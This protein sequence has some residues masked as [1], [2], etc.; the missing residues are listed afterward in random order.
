MQKI[1]LLFTFSF[2]LFHA[3]AQQKVLA[4]KI[5]AKVGDRIILHSD[6]TNEIADMKR[7]GTPLPPSATCG[8]LQNNILGKVLVLQAE[9]DSLKLDDEN[10]EAE[11]DN[12]IR[13]FI[14][15]YGSKEALEE[16]AGKTVYQIKED[17]KQPFRERKLADMMRNKIVEDVKITPTEVKTYFDKIPKDSL[18]FYESALEIGQVVIYP[19]ANKDVDAYIIQELLEYKRQI[20]QEH[21]S[22]ELLAKLYSE[23][24]GSKD[25]GGQY[26]INRNDKFWDPTFLTTAFRLKE[27]QISQPVKSK[28]GYHIIQLVKRNGDDAIVRHILR[29]PPVNDEELKIAINTLDSVRSQIIAGVINFGTAVNKY[30][31]DEESKFNGGFMANQNGSTLVNIDQLDKDMVLILKNMKVNDISQPQVYT[32]QR[33]KK[34][35]RIIYLK[36]RTEPHRENLKD[37]YNRIAQRALD[38]KKNAAM[39]KW[40]NQ[41]TKDYYISI[42][43]EYK[44]CENLSQWK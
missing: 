44:Q 37:D 18:A 8:L 11:L 42:D 24:P 40:F 23:D 1:F 21:K 35:V 10:L 15:A 13:G 28:F 2:L 26:T 32:D 5:I 30:S 31:N 12:Q 20:E 34:A 38:E 41:K 17:F 33:N 9:R 19:K 4:D 22:F 39:Q 36:T 16:V 7:Q 29:I 25:N 6:L 14:Q 3:Q 43:D 27:G